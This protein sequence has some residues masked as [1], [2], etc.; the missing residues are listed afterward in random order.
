MALPNNILQTV[1][2]YQKAELAW[3]LNSCC[4]INLAN[5]KFKNFQN[6]TANLGDTITFD[7]TPRATS[8]YGLITNT[9]PAVQRV[10]NLICSQAINSS[11]A[12]SDQQ[13]LFNVSDY[14]DRFGM[15]RIMQ[16]GSKIEQDLLRNLTSSVTVLNPQDPNFGNPVD[17]TSGPYRFFGDGVT[18]ISSYSQLAQAAANFE[19]YGAANFAYKGIVPITEEPQI[20][21]TGLN[22]FALARNNKDAESWEIGNFAGIDW[23]KSNLLPTHIAG[24]VGQSITGGG[25]ILTLVSTND[26][27][28][29]NITQLTFSG[30]SASDVNAI[31]SSDMFAFQDGVSG[32]PNM[33]FLTFI[34]QSV[35]G[36]SVQFRATANAISDV[37]GNVTVSIFPALVSAPTLNQNLN[38]SLSPG[39]QVKVMNSHRAGVIMSGNPLYLAMPKLPNTAPFD[40]LITMDSETGVSIR[41]YWGFIFGQNQ[42][43]YVWDQIWGSTAVGENMMRLLFP[44]K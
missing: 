2:T 28:G 18:N 29:Q 9:L 22:Q 33:R 27:T 10:Q 21:S 11:I 43:D 31:K 32:Q 7:L 23:S 8:Q 6:E 17:P 37:S 34:G 14:M 41:H 16:I 42:K 12:F 26:P 39:M 24:T 40:S 4:A 35:S 44:L 19:D 30:A 13:F 25:N 3:M 1:A 38:N 36:Q 5:K 15:A 20:I